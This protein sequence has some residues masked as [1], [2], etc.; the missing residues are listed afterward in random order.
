MRKEKREKR[1]YEKDYGFWD[2]VD[3]RVCRWCDNHV[4]GFGVGG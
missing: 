1:D 3:Y 4:V 2:G